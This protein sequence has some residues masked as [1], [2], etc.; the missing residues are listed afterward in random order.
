[1]SAFE[2]LMESDDR[3]DKWQ[4]DGDGLGDAKGEALYTTLFSYE[5]IEWNRIGHFQDVTMRLL[6]ERLLPLSLR[7]ATYL[8]DEL[9][10]HEML[11]PP[12]RGGRRFHLF[13]CADNEGARELASEL[14]ASLGQTL[15]VTCD[16]GEVAACERA[17]LYLNGKTWTSGD[18]NSG[19]LA[20]AVEAA[21]EA[22]VGL[23][24]AHES[25]GEIVQQLHVAAVVWSPRL[26]CGLECGGEGGLEIGG[27]ARAHVN[28]GGRNHLEVPLAHVLHPARELRLDAI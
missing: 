10:C 14:G 6:A 17:L 18:S 1:M 11:V 3:W 8:Q 2:Q 7:G 16:V 13:C 24:L 5:P 4:F 22:G 19:A 12:P 25:L 23:L 15:E 9:T 20:L 28:V 26:G 27:C 21:M